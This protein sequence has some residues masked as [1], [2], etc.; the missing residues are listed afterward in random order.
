[1]GAIV[2][3]ILL[4][5]GS[6]A[7]WGRVP[8]AAAQGSNTYIYLPLVMKPPDVNITGFEVVQSVQ[9]ANNGVPLV[10]NRATVVRVFTT[11]TSGNNL[12]NHSMTL[13][14]V[15]NG[16]PLGTVSTGPQTAS[17]ASS[18]SSYSSTFNFILPANWL[19][20]NVTLTATDDVTG[21]TGS[22]TIN[23]SS[24]PTL[25]VVLVPIRYTHSPTG[26]TFTPPSQDRVS[27][28]VIRAY[29]L[30]NINITFRGD[31][32]FTGNLRSLTSWSSLLTIIGNL[33]S[34]DNAPSSTIYYG[35]IP[36][37]CGWFD[38]GS[39]GYAGYGAIGARFSTG[40][41]L[42]ASWG[43]DA[44]G[45][46]AGH[47]WGHNFG[48]YHAP[49][50]LSEYDSNWPTDPKYNGA[51]IGEFGMDGILAGSPALL[52]PASYVDMMSYCG[53]EWVSDYTYLGL[54]QDQLTSGASATAV[55]QESLLISGRVEADGRITLSPIYT[56]PQ[57]PN[58]APDG[59]YRIE[60]L[61]GSGQVMAAYGAEVLVAEEQGFVSR[62][63]RTAV[64]LPAE[65]VAEV[66]IVAAES[67]AVAAQ[68]TM[69]L[70][71]A[72]FSAFSGDNSQMV[73]VDAVTH[74]AVL[75]WGLP[76]IP[77]IVRYTA[78]NGQTWTALALDVLG[79][80][81]TVDLSALP[82]GN[83]RFQIIPAHSGVPARIDMPLSV[84]LPNN[85]P[86]VW[87]T[88]PSTAVA[89]S[90]AALYGHASDREDG[91]L[92]VTWLVDGKV[93]SAGDMLLLSD[94]APGKHVIKAIAVDDAGVVG[95]YGRI[96]TITS[97]RS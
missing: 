16:T 38:C 37:D 84:T 61:D 41:D 66:R 93:V 71:T 14:A 11:T 8:A 76:D 86:K 9:D 54:M 60:L 77:A 21:A 18:R 4:L 19:S 2:G 70:D 96:I 56:L 24:V 47:E 30:S 1:M 68:Q 23:F 22:T 83:G 78:D 85:A 6:T 10:A 79:G 40:I 36:F 69:Q 88:G 43:A 58:P 33:K 80:E 72:L 57:V 75:R 62:A 26:E 5:S 44:A 81:L 50:G 74:T 39:G 17:A 48:R 45:K 49:C 91:A 89:G 42:P 59:A 52:N 53:P 87:F 90:P 35:Y 34:V 20:G 55:A 63:I 27:D 94:L 67:G 46:L 12:A 3:A 15:R 7:P 28:W 73:Q 25:N 31:Y 82:G 92:P 29:P 64:P 95:E 97:N 51:S 13:T 32:P 65:P